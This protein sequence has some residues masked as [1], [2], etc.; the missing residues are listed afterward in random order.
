MGGGINLLETALKI[1]PWEPMRLLSREELRGMKIVTADDTG[2]EASSGASA[3]SAALA[4][5]T[6]MPV[7]GRSWAMLANAESPTL[8]RSHPL[9]VEGEDIGTFELNFACGE[10]GRDYTVTYIE[11]RRGNEEGAMP[12]A[13]TGV[14]I[15][16]SGKSVPLKVVSSRSNGQPL[17]IDSV[18]NGRLS[19]ELLKAFADASG[20]SLTVETTSDDLST[21]IRVGN[22]GFAHALPQLIASCAGQPRI[23]NTARNEARQGG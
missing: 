20:R 9:T 4:N 3:S 1:P 19:P 7:N 10:A 17:E 8:G 23:R 14:G 6:R 13:V 15:S 22:A 5:G 16:L 18:G 2:V 11:H 12:A 21:V